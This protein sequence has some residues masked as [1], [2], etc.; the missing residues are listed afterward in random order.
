MGAV[1][2]PILCMIVSMYVNGCAN[3]FTHMSLVNKEK[4]VNAS[5]KTQQQGSKSYDLNAATVA[6]N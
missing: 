3:K 5:V 6:W 4:E 1:V 2:P